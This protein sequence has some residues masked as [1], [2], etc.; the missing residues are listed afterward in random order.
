M[1][2]LNQ[3]SASV[4]T[5][6]GWLQCTHLHALGDSITFGAA[7][8]TF[9][10]YPERLAAVLQLLPANHGVGSANI[11]RY[12]AQLLPGWSHPAGGA[13]SPAS[14]GTG[15]FTVIWGDYNGLRD[16]GTT[17]AYQAHHEATLRAL[18][19]YAAVPTSAL[20][21]GQSATVTKTGTWGNSD[22]YG[23]ALGVESQ[24]NGDSLTVDFEGDTLYLAYVA[25]AAPSASYAAGVSGRPAADGSVFAVAVDGVSAATGLNN[26]SAYGN[27]AAYNGADGNDSIKLDYAPWCVRLGGFGPGRHTAVVTITTASATR[28]LTFLWAIGSDQFAYAPRIG[29]AV[30]IVNTIRPLLAG[31]GSLGSEANITAALR[32][33][34]SAQRKVA[35][36]FQA[37]GARVLV[38]HCPSYDPSTAAG[39]NVHPSA[40]GHDQ[41]TADLA[42][43]VGPMYRRHGRVWIG[44]VTVDGQLTSRGTPTN[45]VAPAGMV[46]EV[47]TAAVSSSSPVALTNNTVASVCSLNLT[48]GDWEVDG[49]VGFSLTGATCQNFVTGQHTSAALGAE[50]TFNKSLI[51]TTTLTDFTHISTPRLRW[52]VSANTTVHLLAR[53][54]FTAGSVGAWGNLR[55]RRVR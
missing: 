39:D 14:I 17:A 19:C 38:G 49:Y 23:G 29:P 16:F 53:A 9:G 10:G 26:H 5:L 50:G 43:A 6:M 1:L 35:S 21:L 34:H 3:P 7:A 22:K 31:A 2:N 52:S 13:N 25:H 47:V 54:G 24:T 41:I 37:D 36:E 12:S 8:G 28:P 44:P 32:A 11:T 55:A 15:D 20:R 40:T 45:D 27:R 48:P 18:A 4:G 30:L 46:G 42:A 33:F 51:G